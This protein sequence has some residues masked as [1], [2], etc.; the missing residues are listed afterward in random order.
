M[1]AIRTFETEIEIEGWVYKMSVDYS[2]FIDE[3]PPGS[4]K[5]ELGVDLHSVSII[6][7]EG[8]AADW[9]FLSKVDDLLIERIKES[10]DE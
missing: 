8:E 9:P 3:V 4:G 6:N 7:E 1:T 10:F 2:P 5:E